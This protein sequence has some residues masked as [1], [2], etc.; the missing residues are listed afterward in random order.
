M[1]YT[2]DDMIKT[3]YQFNRKDPEA[4]IIREYL[5]NTDNCRKK[6]KNEKELNEGLN[7]IFNDT[8]VKLGLNSKQKL[9][10]KLMI[11]SALCEDDEREWREQKYGKQE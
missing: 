3:E 1:L 5:D 9:I 8:M 4:T 11:Y 2:T 10:H 7:N 6:S